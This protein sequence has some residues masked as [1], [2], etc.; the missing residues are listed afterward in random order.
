MK[1]KKAFMFEGVMFFII[2]IL[3]ITAF[4]TLYKKQNKFPEGYMIGERQFGLIKTYQK[5]EQALFY[6]D[7]SAK[8][9]AYQTIYDLG[10]KGGY[11]TSDCGDYFGYN[12]WVSLDDK[13]NPK[14]CYPEKEYAES[15]KS[16][17]S[18]N[19]D[20]YLVRYPDVKIPKDNYDFSLKIENNKLEIIG[21]AIAKLVF[22][23]IKEEETFSFTAEESLDIALPEKSEACILDGTYDD[24][25]GEKIVDV[26]RNYEKE[27]GDLP[28]VWGGES[29]E[30]GGFDCSGFVYSVF[31][32]SNI[33]GFDYRLTARDY[34]KSCGKEISY[35]ELEPGDL[36][37]IDYNKNDVVDHVTI[38]LGNDNIIHSSSSNK[39]IKEEKI[40]KE[41]KERIY[42]AKRYA[43]KQEVATT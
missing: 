41:Y 26:A 14:E 20:E 12:L 29:E 27:Y 34:E 31:K 9:S 33:C 24:D 39:G 4:L 43:L 36:I 35:S 6:I 1:G 19:L 38:Y 30:E 7:Q 23:I 28:Y 8:Y 25:K 15:F 11:E 32:D 17:F 16:I 3:L 18:K 21:K 37:F 42:S 40:P 2:L 22:N 5:A 13:K 10:Q